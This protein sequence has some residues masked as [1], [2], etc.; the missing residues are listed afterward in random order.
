MTIAGLKD[1]TLFIERALIGGAWR[2]AASGETIA[3]DDPATGE[4][5]GSVPDCDGADTRAAIDAAAA[6]FGPW[7]R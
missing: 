2:S 1:P 6:A 4:I 3:V 7:R 5:L